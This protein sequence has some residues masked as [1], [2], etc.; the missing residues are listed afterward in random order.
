MK[1]LGISVE[2]APMSPSLYLF[3]GAVATNHPGCQFH[4]VVL[5]LIVAHV[6]GVSPATAGEP[7]KHIN[8]HFHHLAAVRSGHDTKAAIP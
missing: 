8:V 6:T 1:F 5:V 7:D 4:G 3:F 2:K